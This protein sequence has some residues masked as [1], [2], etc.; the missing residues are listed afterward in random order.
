MGQVLRTSVRGI[1]LKKYL[2][3]YAILAVFS[4][5]I[6]FLRLMGHSFLRL[7]ALAILSNS[8]CIAGKRAVIPEQVGLS[9][10]CE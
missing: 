9:N 6:A 1:D 7:S 2:N 3:C 5:Q 10:W 8:G 4:R